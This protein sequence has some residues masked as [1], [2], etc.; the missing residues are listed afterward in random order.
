VPDVEKYEILVLGSGEA[1]KYIAWTMAKE[2][3]RTALV[4]RRWLGGSC[5]NIACL[6][7]KNLIYSARVASLAR[8]GAEFGLEMD[9]LMV[10]MAGV[11]RRKREMVQGL[12]EM[13]AA[14]TVA[15]GVE[16][17]MG[18]GRFVAP[19]TLE[20]ALNDGGTRRAEGERVFLVLGSRATMPNVPGLA[21]ANPMTHIEALDLDRLPAH[22]IVIGGGYVGLELSQAMRWFGSRVTV[23]EQG[24]QLAGREDSDVGAAL[25][26]LFQAEG[27]DVLLG[28][29]VSRVEG[30]SGRKIRVHVKDA[31]SEGVL[32]G[33]DLL[34]AT[35]R[36]PI[37]GGI[38]LERAGVKLNEHGY[39]NVNDQLETTAANVWAM[40]DC[41]GSPQFTHVAYNDFR[42]VHDNLNG[43]N[44]TTKDRL[45]PFCM[46]TDP[47]LVRVGLNESE[48]QRN[49]IEYRLAKMPMA[50]VL[51]T[52]TVAERRGFMKILIS[53][54]NDEILGFTAFG[55]EASELMAAVQTAMVGRIPYTVLRDAIFTHPTISEGLVFLLGQV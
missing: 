1:G 35:G 33:T 14:R 7:S 21:A 44:R 48:A 40:G 3:R 52:R 32:E 9:S 31:H 13:H 47:E 45:V 2:G 11:Q 53:K 20:I 22:L 16:L 51:R 19:R 28:T 24:R 17:I 25:L 49:G 42:V 6:P 38:G 8:R 18:E 5:P 34:V 41:A 12:Y 29:T 43:G 27:I 15:S 23:I 54:G 55:F 30:R 4:E 46:F 39:I 26:D 10:S 50:D 37:T 36:M